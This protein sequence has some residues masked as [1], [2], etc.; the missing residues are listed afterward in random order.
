[1]LDEQLKVSLFEALSNI[2]LKD[3]G[4]SGVSAAMLK[5]P[6]LKR[7]MQLA[8]KHL[9]ANNRDGFRKGSVYA[10][11]DIYS[12]AIDE[13]HLCVSRIEKFKKA[14]QQMRNKENYCSDLFIFHSEFEKR[15]GGTYE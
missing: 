2:E 13:L 7:H 1:M 8:L 9:K 14:T 6:L 4:F 10:E 5:N 12:H 11:A 15:H 3:I